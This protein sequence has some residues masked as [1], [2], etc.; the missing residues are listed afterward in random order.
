[1]VRLARGEEVEGLLVF[2]RLG[3]DHSHYAGLAHA[4]GAHKGHPAAT[5]FDVATEL[6]AE[7]LSDSLL[8]GCRL[9]HGI[10]R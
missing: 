8:L 7:L 6:S 1:M 9:G 3:V 10:L 5:V 2:G 4:F